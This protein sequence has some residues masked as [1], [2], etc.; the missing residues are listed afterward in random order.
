MKLNSPL[1]SV[2]SIYLLSSVEQKK[3]LDCPCD[4]IKDTLLIGERE[5]N[6]KEILYQLVIC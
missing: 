4:L 2:L 3:E 6:Y 1:V 5:L